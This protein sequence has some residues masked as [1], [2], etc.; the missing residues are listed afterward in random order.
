MFHVIIA[1]AEEEI[2]M[3]ITEPISCNSY[4]LSLT[5]C[6]NGQECLKNLLIDNRINLVIT[7]IFMDQ[8]GGISLTKAL[9]INYPDICVVGLNL[10]NLTV[11]R[12]AFHISG[13]KAVIEDDGKESIENIINLLAEKKEVQ[14]QDRLKAFI[15]SKNP[16]LLQDDLDLL[17]DYELEN[18]F[19]RL[20]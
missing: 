13:A 1:S 19:K 2:V 17:S 4:I 15:R 20:N 18:L 14:R 7:D 12:D 9:S 8:M 5:R 6:C 16:H 11:F 10:N 3:R